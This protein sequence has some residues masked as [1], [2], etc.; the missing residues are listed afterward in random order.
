MKNTYPEQHDTHERQRGG[1]TSAEGEKHDSPKAKKIP[2]N[3]RWGTD[4]QKPKEKS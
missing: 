1:N 3:R 2:E 4:A